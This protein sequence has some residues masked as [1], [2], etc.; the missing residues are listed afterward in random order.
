MSSNSVSAR[1]GVG[2]LLHKKG[3]VWARRE[4]EFKTSRNVGPSFMNDPLSYRKVR[5]LEVGDI[6]LLTPT[7][8]SR[9]PNRRGF[10]LFWFSY[11][12]PTFPSLFTIPRISGTLLENLPSWECTAYSNGSQPVWVHRLLWRFEVSWW[13]PKSF[14]IFSFSILNSTIIDIKTVQTSKDVF[15]RG[16]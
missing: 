4:R 1:I 15:Q 10:P 14:P 11:T 5:W 9:L 2:G 8:Y 13:L 12:L 6:G 3:Q 7:L 16:V